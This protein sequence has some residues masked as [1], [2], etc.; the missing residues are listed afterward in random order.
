MD[1]AALARLAA[2]AGVAG[3]AVH[4]ALAGGHAGHAPALFAALGVL[5]LVCVP[6]G[7]SLLRRPADRAA[8]TTLLV[9]SGLMM[10]L[11]LAMDPRGPMLAVVLAVPGLQVLL[12]LYSVRITAGRTRA[13]L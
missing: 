6:C 5:A 7:L 12:F 1:H 10:V 9:L 4:L 8:W 3:V 13:P 2:A 11:H